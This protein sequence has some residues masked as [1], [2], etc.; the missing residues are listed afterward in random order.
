MKYYFSLLFILFSFII[1]AQSSSEIAESYFKNSDYAKASIYYKKAVK[2]TID[3]KNNYEHY[4]T[5][6]IVLKEYKTL[7]KLS[8]RG[9]KSFPGNT[10]YFLDNIINL[11]IEG[12]IDNYNKAINKYIK[13]VKKQKDLVLIG[14]SHLLK[15]KE[16]KKTTKLY[17]TSRKSIGKEYLYA[18]QL[19]EIYQNIEKISPMV[20]EYI[21]HLSYKP[22]EIEKIQN[23]LQTELK[24]K[25]LNLLIDK[26]YK[27]IQLSDKTIY[28]QLLIWA[29]L[30]Q[31]DF[32]NAFIQERAID[33]KQKLNGERL[34]NLAIICKENKEYQTRISIFEYLVKT[35]P[36]HYN[37]QLFQENLLKAKQ[38]KAISVYPINTIALQKILQEYLTLEKTV[39]NP[40]QKASISLDIAKIYGYYLN[41]VNKA[42]NKLKNIQADR[43]IR[44]NMRN[45]IKLEL[46]D[47]YLFQDDSQASL[48]Y[49]QIAKSM[50]ETELGQLAK[51]KNAKY[52]YY[53]GDFQLAKSQL[54]VLKHAT[55]RKISND[56]IDLSVLIQNNYELDTSA[57]ALQTFSKADFYIYQHK[58][59]QAEN[60]YK[61]MLKTYPGHT[62]TDEIYWKIA[63]LNINMNK[64]QETEKFYL[65]IIKE[66]GED[67]LADDA[68]FNLAQLYETRLLDKNK[69]Q[70]MYKK[71][72]FEY[73]GSI[74]LDQSRKKFR[75]LRGDKL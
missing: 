53:Q 42:I 47:L 34:L 49:F 35:Y 56:A 66:Y 16:I 46:A 52:F 50:K 4:R 10:I 40:Q 44:L 14:G 59:T 33:K 43:R 63:Q 55:T 26:L 31:R 68:V 60:I 62:L 73:R 19:A 70:E 30:Q 18:F 7:K 75:E 38:Q 48:L 67:I 9:I 69:A 13:T 32:Y 51:L 1:K 74:Y 54:D 12:D 24:N 36:R 65:K 58:Y 29:Y 45:K 27:K 5:S 23:I 21:N 22:K 28:P 41:E 3:F 8:K 64:Y 72:L 57:I 25:E 61:R 17:L 71:I 11:K 20:D 2:S 6:L 37:Y 15:R 39:N